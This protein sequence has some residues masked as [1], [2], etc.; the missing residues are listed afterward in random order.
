MLIYK[1]ESVDYLDDREQFLFYYEKCSPFR[2]NKI[3]RLVSLKD[4]KLSLGVDVLL[5]R[6]LIENGIYSQNEIPPVKISERGKPLFDKTE[7]LFFSLSHSENMV[8]C[9]I[10]D[11]L[12]GCDIEKITF[13]REECLSISKQ[14]FNEHEYNCINTL[15]DE[16]SQIA[17]YKIWTLK[18]AYAKCYDLSLSSILIKDIT[19]EDNIMKTEIENNF[20]Y[21]IVNK[22]D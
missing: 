10:S 21:S 13:S 12:I 4:K 17:F 7:N 16:A 22:E 20:V 6:L 15:K 18:E 9:A 3:D 5:K 2:K 1:V 14:F 8:M 19:T 11:S